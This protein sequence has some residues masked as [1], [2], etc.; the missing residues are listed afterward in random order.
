[1][2][3][4]N[5]FSVRVNFCNFHSVVCKI[6]IFLSVEK[7]FVKSSWFHGKSWTQRF[8]L[9]KSLTRNI[10]NVP[11][12]QFLRAINEI[13]F[14][15]KSN[16]RKNEFSLLHRFDEFLHESRLI[17]QFFDKLFIT[18]RILREIIYTQKKSDNRT[19]WRIF[20]SKQIIF[21]L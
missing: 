4:R 13:Y 5:F 14:T 18:I 12:F 19:L 2:I 8:F 11:S 6:S 1:M 10:R 9:V 7:Y 15:E 16:M 17:L 21:K 3:R 20:V